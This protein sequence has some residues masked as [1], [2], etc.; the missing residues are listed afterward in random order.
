MASSIAVQ[1]SSTA[2]NFD[3][4]R[5]D[6]MLRSFLFVWRSAIGSMMSVR[7]STVYFGGGT[8]AVMSRRSGIT[9]RSLSW[10]RHIVEM[11]KYMS[12]NFAVLDTS[13]I[14]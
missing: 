12:T 5:G 10:V 3:V 7:N 2:A 11:I 4:D 6:V 9:S 8:A 13:G 1:W 14:D